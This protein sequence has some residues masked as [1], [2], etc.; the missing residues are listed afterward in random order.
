MNPVRNSRFRGVRAAIAVVMSL[1]AMTGALVVDAQAAALPQ[2]PP[3]PQLFPAPGAVVLPRDEVPHQ[4]QLEWWYFVGHLHGTDTTGAAREFGYEVTVFQL[5]PL[6]VGSGALYSWH[7]AITDVAGQVYRFEERVSAAPIP[8]P[9]SGFDFTN[10]NWSVS[11]AQQNYRIAARLGDGAYGIDLRTRSDHTFVVHSRVGSGLIDY[12]PI[13]RT[14]AYYSST[15]LDTTGTVTLGGQRI[16]VT[17][18]SWQDRQWFNKTQME[19]GGWNWFALQLDHDTQYMLYFLQD[20]QTG[21][22]VNTI[23]TKVVAGRAT[24]LSADQMSV[25]GLG[26]WRSPVSGFTYP[27]RWRITVPGGQFQVIPQV[28][29]QELVS[30]GHRTYFEGSSVVTGSLDGSATT[31]RAYVEVNPW[32]QPYTSLP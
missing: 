26:S 18:I 22:I 5:R 6:N 21:A 9:H 7:F 32:D 27:A 8:Q 1:C 12:T 13:A 25:L 30:P 15:S 14:S 24:P 28:R 31:G 11:G 2:M 16:S 20:P 19:G 10:G 23:G 4:N 3:L 17:G 29:N